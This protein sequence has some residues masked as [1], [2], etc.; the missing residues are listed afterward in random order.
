M[1]SSYGL[2]EIDIKDIGK[3]I[4]PMVKVNFSIVMVIIIMEIGFTI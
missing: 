1:A 2:M 4:K 3:M